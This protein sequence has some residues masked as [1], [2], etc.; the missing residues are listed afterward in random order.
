MKTINNKLIRSLTPCYDPSR[1][2]KDEVETLT[3]LDWLNKYRGIVPDKDITWLLCHEE[4]LSE[5][6]L[7]LFAVWCAREVLKLVDNPDS[8]SIE[9]CNVAERYANGAATDMQLKAAADD[10]AD[11]DDSYAA[12]AA[13]YVADYYADVA[14]FY[15]ADAAAYF[16]ANYYADVVATYAAYFAAYLA[17]HTKQLDKLLTYFK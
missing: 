8:R 14:A 17:A 2:I 1:Y 3:I 11:A 9:A 4:F 15:A 13:I 6:D 10:A 5:K 7:R 16:A 12:D